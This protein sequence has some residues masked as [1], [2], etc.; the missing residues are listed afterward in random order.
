[1]TKKEFIDSVRD[2]LGEGIARPDIDTV[3]SALFDAFKAELKE[4]G[5]VSWPGF[6]GFRVKERAA[7]TGTNPRT[8]ETIKIPASKTVTFRLSEPLKKRLNS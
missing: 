4:N 8:K 6:G 1:M 3:L 7:R 2:A 5:S